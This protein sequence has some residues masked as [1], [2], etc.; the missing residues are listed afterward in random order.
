VRDPGIAWLDLG[1]LSV[2]PAEREPTRSIIVEIKADCFS[3]RTP[4]MFAIA[5]SVL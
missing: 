2:L 5:D 3:F 1:E 4:A